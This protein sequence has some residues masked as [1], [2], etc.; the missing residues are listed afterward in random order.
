V[1]YYGSFPGTTISGL[2]IVGLN[3]SDT[4]SKLWGKT[5]AAFRHAYRNYGH[6]VDWFY[7]ADDD[8]YAVMENMR[9]LLKPYSPSNPIYFGSPFK[10]GSTLYMS[11]GAGYVLSKSAVELL[12][13]G[14]AENC[15]PGDQ[16]TED[17]VMGK[18]LSLLQVQAGDSRDLLGRQRFFSLSLEHFLIPNRDN[19]GFWLQEYL[20]QTTGTV[21][22]KRFLSNHRRDMYLYFTFRD[23]NAVL[24]IQFPYTM[25]LRTKCIFWKR[26]CIKGDHMDF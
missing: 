10:L 4:R 21:S 12:N 20:Y 22:I 19:E 1:I 25:F 18:C 8:T 9:K 2:E 15:Q 14:A 6:E 24:P 17:Y 5:K 7:K 26:F 11:G 23:W 3:A 16:G 13:L